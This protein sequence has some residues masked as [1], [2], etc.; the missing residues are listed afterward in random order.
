MRWRWTRS[1]GNA[2]HRAPCYAPRFFSGRTWQRTCMQ[3]LD[4]NKLK[5]AYFRGRPARGPPRRGGG[6][7]GGGGGRAGRGGGAG[8]GAGRGGGAGGGRGAGAGG[9]AAGG[10]GPAGGV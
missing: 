10:A 4:E 1:Y 8:G 7:G 5:Q 9:G 6:G 3:A 2:F